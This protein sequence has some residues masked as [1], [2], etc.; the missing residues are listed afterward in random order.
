MV[1]DLRK[2]N[3]MVVA[4]EFPLPR[5]E[6]IL[7]A[8]SGSQ[9]LTTLDAL[10]GFTQL[11]MSD[12]AAEKLAFRTH[13]GLWQFR[14]MPFGYRNG[15]SVFQRVMHNV[16][17][18]FLWIFALVY[19]DDIVVFSLTFEEHIR[20]L[21]QVFSAIS[22]AH[23]TLSPGKCHFAY[24]SLLL[25]GQKVS[26]L[27]LSTHKEKVDAILQLNE[28]RN[29]HELQ[30]FLGMMVY[31]SAYV[32]FYSWIAHPLFQLLKKGIKWEWTELEQEA[33]EIC[34]QVLT[35]APVRGYAMA[36]RPFR[37]YSDACDY[38]L[39]AILQQ[40]QPILIRDLRGTRLYERLE[41]AFKSKEPIP[42]LVTAVKG[43]NDIP[44][45]GEWALNFEDT[46]VHIERVI[47]YWSRVLKSP[48]RNYSPTEREALALKEALIKFQP[49]LEG[50]TV[51][52]ITDHAALTWSRT[53]QNVNRRL[54]TWG[55]VF[56][57]YPDLKIVHRAGR[58]HSNVDPISRLRR[59]VPI[60]DSPN[61]D[62]IPTVEL[63]GGEDPLK[64]MY[65]DLGPKF[66]EKLL[67]VATR[68]V[69][70]EDSVG[71]YN[72]IHLGP[73]PIDE[74]GELNSNYVT[75]R[76]YNI[77]IGMS[78]KELTEW[79]SAYSLDPH[80]S[81]VI[82]GLKKETNWTH[83][84]Y[85]QYHYSDS[86]LI[87]FEDWQGNNRLCVPEK[88]RVPIMD[89]VHNT[90]TESAHAG[91][92]RCYNRLATTYYWP[93]MS[94]DLKRY[95][96]SCD[97]CQKA[98]PR[99][100]APTGL[101]QP[102]P[103]PTQPFEVISMDF[104][105]ELPK[106]GEFDNILVIVDKLTKY[107]IFIP[108]STGITELETAK[109]FFQHVITKFGI[110]KQVIT[111]RDTRWR[112]DFWAEV[113]RL[114]GMKRALT[115]S[116]HP[117]ADG[118]TENLNQTLEIALRAYVSPARNDWAQFLDG[119]ALSYNSTPHTSTNFAPAFLL[120]GYT[121]IT[122]STV[123]SHSTAIPR[124][125][126]QSARGGDGDAVI[127]NDKAQ[128]MV[129]EFESSRTRAK[130]SLLLAQVFQKR[131]YNNGRLTTEFEE[132]DMVVLNPHSLGLLKNEKGRGKKL[133]MK[134][135][136]PFE[137]IRKLSPVTYQL[138]LPVSYGIHPIL[139]IAH[140]EAYERSP[141]EFG[142]RPTKSLNR[143]DFDV[144]PEVD[145]QS[146]IRS[147]GAESKA[148]EFN[149]SKLDGKVLVQR[150][151]SG[152]PSDNFEMRH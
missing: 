25:L 145:I 23:L 58:I 110:P 108:C 86:G 53:F 16:L 93:R 4:D 90:L 101:L 42:V 54:L 13:R 79:A 144:T 15:P 105:P 40:V 83:P 104:I 140:L 2:L 61:S 26:R 85:P 81:E 143:D 136:G 131:A 48:E 107:S 8:L 69:H 19:I 142:S 77:L 34:K 11:T 74:S 59:R 128:Q 126:N 102:I 152:S 24:Q 151:M 30:Q 56:S 28:P 113:C 117:Q 89:E 133:H 129:D 141:P 124:P 38:G 51:I 6:D 76:S 120:R 115:T 50:E 44:L 111:D 66:E 91:Y 10:A 125:I 9:W 97:I 121:P 147:A 36:G 3:E 135:D 150:T 103:I 17:A 32:P 148:E 71:E 72:V 45:P 106:S 60:Q 98:K 7:Q 134:Y 138:R 47:C 139:N 18:P 109:L 62:K 92:H 116:Y 43:V 122:A 52:A 78:E 99:R 73:V 149:N 35:N 70:G 1:I 75:S 88:F 27:G 137:V 87:Y 123:I 94:R 65:E 119:F 20:H 57:A 39:A 46:T 49:F 80:F 132:G 68:F 41:R 95:V 112:H 67:T 82:K 118:Q 22:A 84:H 130:E 37:V 21:D 63:T 5:Q 12:S 55:T 29:V 64:N 31:F 96:S 33:F 14:R 127:I 146:I 100:H 114:M